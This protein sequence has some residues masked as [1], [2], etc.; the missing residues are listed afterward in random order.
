[1][2]YTSAE[3]NKLLK[4]LNEERN[5]LLSDEN[6]KATFTA[7]IEENVEDVRPE[8]SLPNAEKDIHAVEEKIRTVKHAI[9]MFNTTH[10]I[11]DITIDEILVLIPMLIQKKLRL[12][13]LAG[14]LEK[15]RHNDF[16]SSGHHIEYDYA[17]FDIKEA[18]RMLDE[19]TDRL[20]SLQLSL[21][22]ANNSATMEINV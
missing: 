5:R 19:V 11:G 12:Q 14:M 17:N 3:A 18:R 9:N 8:F 20:S 22:E 13:H 1:M 7:A 21:D 2:K 10:K 4:K 6:Q 16:R 15:S